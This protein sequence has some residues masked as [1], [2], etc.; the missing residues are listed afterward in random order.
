MYH[1][2]HFEEVAEAS[3]YVLYQ[4]LDFRDKKPVHSGSLG[5]CTKA[6]RKELGT[7]VAYKKIHVIIDNGAGRNLKEQR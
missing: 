7:H 1:F 4:T 5:T 3:D 6:Y 2:R